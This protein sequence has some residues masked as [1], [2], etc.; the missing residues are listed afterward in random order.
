MC[1]IVLLLTGPKGQGEWGLRGGAAADS[2]AAGLEDPEGGGV[3][4]LGPVRSRFSSS[5]SDL[6][7]FVVEGGI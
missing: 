5:V 6:R 3:S 4:G 2:Q 7:S 1:S